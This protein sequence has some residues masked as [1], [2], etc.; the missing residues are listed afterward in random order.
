MQVEAGTGVT[1]ADG[2]RGETQAA[3]PP[4]QVERIAEALA[5]RPTN[6][7]ATGAR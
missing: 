5:E 7:P 2:E 3:M 1:T 6:L 4:E